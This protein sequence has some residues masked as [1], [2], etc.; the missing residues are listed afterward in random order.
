MSWMNGISREEHAELVEAAREHYRNGDWS[1]DKFREQL[2]IL[3]FNAT[4]IDSEVRDI[5]SL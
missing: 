4:E 3:G 2:A 1:E 5:D